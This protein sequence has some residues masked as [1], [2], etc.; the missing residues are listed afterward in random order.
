MR[1]GCD[2]QR[3]QTCY[4]PRSGGQRLRFCTSERCRLAVPYARLNPRSPAVLHLRSTMRDS[5]DTRVAQMR[6]T[7]NGPVGLQRT[8][9]VYASV[10]ARPWFMHGRSKHGAE[11]LPVTLVLERRSICFS[12]ARARSGFC[13]RRKN[14]GKRPRRLAF[15]SVACT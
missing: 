14:E 6:T 9:R 5:A 1:N 4:Y 12:L 2:A 10:H 13:N 11:L 7:E 8:R 3:T 15:R